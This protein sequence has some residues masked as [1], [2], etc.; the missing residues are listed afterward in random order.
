MTRVATLL[1]CVLCSAALS[2]Q[3]QKPPDAPSS[4]STK[5]DQW[6]YSPPTQKERFKTYL[7]HTFG[8]YSVVEAAARGG[9]D[10]ARD[11]P[12][13][14][15]QGGQGYADR[16]GSAMGQIAIRGTTEYLVSD[17]LR[18]DNRRVP[19][20][21][22][23]PESKFKRALEDTFTARKGDDGHRVFSVARFSGPIVAGTV[24]TTTWYPSGYR[25]SE[26]LRQTG[27]NYAFSFIRNY[28][29]E[30]THSE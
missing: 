10:Q 2:G 13:Q 29:R 6:D 8:I 23:C 4:I 27:A 18:E 5:H 15:P 30:L 24:S 17:L 19:C 14:W 9:I 1:F 22:S 26:L 11:A 28:I 7:S 16:L 21:P 3:E 12:S 25:K 20:G